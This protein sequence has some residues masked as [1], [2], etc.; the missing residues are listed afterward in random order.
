MAGASIVAG[1]STQ[2][3]RIS[4]PIDLTRSKRSRVRL[5]KGETQMN[6]LAPYRMGDSRKPGPWN[7]PLFGPGGK[8]NSGPRRA[9]L[10]R[11]PTSE[12]RTCGPGERGQTALVNCFGRRPLGGRS[13]AVWGRRS[14]ASQ[15][16]NRGQEGARLGS[17]ASYGDLRIADRSGVSARGPVARNL[18]GGNDD[19]DRVRSRGCG[20]L[21]LALRSGKD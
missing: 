18:G 6:V 9:R 20:A 17:G 3:S 16:G 11:R 7:L 1:S 5:E 12:G 14:K 21:A 19:D 10:L 15:G 4:K 2:I 13:C 8:E